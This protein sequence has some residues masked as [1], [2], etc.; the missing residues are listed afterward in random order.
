MQFCNLSEVVVREHDTTHA[1]KDKVETASIL[2]TFQSMLTDFRY[3]RSTW[4][5]NV[6]EER[7]L[8]VSLT[9][10]MDNE[11]TAGLQGYDRLASALSEL[12]QIA[13]STNTDWARRLNIPASTAVT[14]GKPSGT[15]SQ[16]VDAASGIHRRFANFYVRTVRNDK[17]DPLSTFMVDKGVPHETDVTKPGNWVFSFPMKSPPHASVVSESTTAVEQLEHYLV[18]A[19][20]W[21]EHNVSVTIYVRENE[22][23]EVGAWVYRHFNDINGVSFLPYSDH[24]YKQAPYQAI[25]EEKY[26]ELAAAFP[27]VDFS[28]YVVDEHQDNTQG[29]GMLACVGGACEIL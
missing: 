23:P 9:G 29:A 25:D 5:K 18:Y 14:C 21:A 20:H 7:L 4:R 11:L 15:V 13:I 28:D 16:L 2:G 27:A 8:G 10:I 26:L 19:K 1:L 24:V 22:W 17:A 6:E 3:L 12:K